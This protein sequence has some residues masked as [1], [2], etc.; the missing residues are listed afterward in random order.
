MDYRFF[1]IRHAYM[2]INAMLQRIAPAAADTPVK[3][4]AR[5]CAGVAAYDGKPLM[6]IALMPLLQK[7]TLTKP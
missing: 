6:K 2:H 7:T 4:C 5:A 1:N 3:L